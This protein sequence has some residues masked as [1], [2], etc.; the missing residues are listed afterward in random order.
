MNSLIN[1]AAFAVHERGVEFK[2]PDEIV[3]IEEMGYY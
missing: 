1:P 3:Q 2:T